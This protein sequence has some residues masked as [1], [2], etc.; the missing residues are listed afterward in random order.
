M[1]IL[2]KKAVINDADRLFSIQKQSFERLYHIYQDDANPYLRGS[3]E[4]K[5]QIENGTR[6]IYSIFVDGIL[7][8][9]IAI[10]NRGGGEYYLNRIYVL[11]QLQGKGK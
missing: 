5:N 2:V 7:S 9:G 6:D 8:G 1:N 11:P 3:D 10:R 4:I